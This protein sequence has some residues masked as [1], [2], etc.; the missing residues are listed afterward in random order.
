MFIPLTFITLVFF[1]KIPPFVS[2]FS[3][4]LL[5]AG[6]SITTS[7]KNFHVVDASKRRVV[8][9]VLSIDFNAFVSRPNLSRQFM[10]AMIAAFEVRFTNPY[11]APY[12]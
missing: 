12:V 9:L 5:S 6:K 10:Y 1:D 11:F 8:G 4:Q 2:S 3:S 7:F